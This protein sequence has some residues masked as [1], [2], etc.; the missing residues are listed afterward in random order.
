MAEGG[1]EMSSNASSNTK[2]NAISN[3]FIDTTYNSRELNDVLYVGVVDGQ[4]FLVVSSSTAI[5][6]PSSLSK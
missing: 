6:H 4:T 2:S 5:A 3:T 1:W